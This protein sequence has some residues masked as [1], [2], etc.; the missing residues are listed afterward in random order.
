MDAG[1][2]GVRGKSKVRELGARR[3]IEDS[4]C[5]CAV[6]SVADLYFFVQFFMQMS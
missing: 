1:V 2:F 4:Q 6:S 3:G 5:T